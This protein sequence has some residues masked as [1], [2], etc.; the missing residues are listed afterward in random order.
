[1]NCAKST[2]SGDRSSTS[3]PTFEVW[4]CLSLTSS[5]RRLIL[6]DECAAHSI[7]PGLKP[8][9]GL[10]ARTLLVVVPTYRISRRGMKTEHNPFNE[11]CRHPYG[12][13][14]DSEWVCLCHERMGNDFYFLPSDRCLYEDE[15]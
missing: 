2:P 14:H 4:E 12:P 11:A 13:I 5:E 9:D 8:L 15:P 6:I 7:L 3:S 10:L 1:M